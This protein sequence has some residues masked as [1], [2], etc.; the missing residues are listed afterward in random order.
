MINIKIFLCIYFAPLRGEPLEV[1][2]LGLLAFSFQFWLLI[3]VT[4]IIRVNHAVLGSAMSGS[5]LFGKIAFL[6]ALSK[7]DS[8]IIYL[9][10]QY[11]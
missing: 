9:F 8:Q 10:I 4:Q 6:L 7:R 1:A 2:A 3:C 5:S 11:S